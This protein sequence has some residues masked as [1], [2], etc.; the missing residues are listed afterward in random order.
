MSKP[1]NRLHSRFIPQEEI[2]DKA[3]VQWRFAAVDA[4]GSGFAAAAPAQFQSFTTAALMPAQ[5]L[6]GDMFEMEELDSAPPS[7]PAV[8]EERLQQMLEQARA[9]G[10]AQG[11]A[12]GKAQTRQEWQQHMDDYVAGAGREGVQ[13]LD[14]VVEAM[15][16][17]FKQ[18]QAGVASELLNLA[19]EIARQVVRQELRSQP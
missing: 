7:A 9:E 2:D 3:V 19:C 5:P 16:A 6:P 12:Q 15:D 17:S 13:R 8:D 10:H 14:A 4:P 18:M 11:L 1:G